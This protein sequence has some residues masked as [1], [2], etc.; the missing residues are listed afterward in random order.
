[1]N[2]IKIY[3]L[4]GSSIIIHIFFMFWAAEKDQKLHIFLLSNIGAVISITAI[5]CVLSIAYTIMNFMRIKFNE[6]NNKYDHSKK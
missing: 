6:F 4:I 1:M 2:E 5:F 3:A